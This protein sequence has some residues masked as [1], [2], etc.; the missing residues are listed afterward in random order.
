MNFFEKLKTACKLNPQRVIFSDGRDERIIA[1]ARYLKDN[2]LAEPLILGGNFEIRDL[3][4]AH[5]IKTRGLN[6]INPKNSAQLN[7][8]MERIKKTYLNSDSFAVENALKEPLNFA[9]Q[10]VRFGHADLVMAGNQGT[11]QNVASS[12]IR[13]CGI[14]QGYQRLSSFYLMLS[15]DFRNVVAFADCSINVNPTADQLVEI[16][17]KTA[18]NFEKI[19]DRQARIALLS[20][21]TKGSAAHPRVDLVKKAV[22]KINKASP[23]IVA[24]GELQFDAA[25][26]PLVAEKKAPNGS[27]NGKA[28]VFIFPALNASNIGQKIAEHVA[29]YIS[30]G[31]ML[32][33]LKFAVHHLAKS[34]TVEGIINSVLLASYMKIKN[35]N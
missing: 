26:D 3:A 16:A 4:D 25:I 9:I 23:Q 13:H 32:Q 10:K 1:A 34:C 6:I 18:Q 35:I 33:G 28:N 24:D 30:I 20:F 14:L 27:L 22:Q 11:M 31:P 15:K 12:A 7:P 29:G 17:L 2:E 5:K 21:S 8:I 19:T